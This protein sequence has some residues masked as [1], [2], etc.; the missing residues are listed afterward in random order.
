MLK[1]TITYED[2]NGEKV[3][4]DFYFNLSKAEIARLDVSYQRG[5]SEYAKKLIEAEDHATVVSIFED[6][7][8]LSVGV[9][10]EDGR[11][12]IKSQE[13]TNDFMQ[14]NAY[15]ELFMELATNTNKAIE[16]FKGLIPS[17][18]VAKFEEAQNK[19]YSDEELL[20]MSDEEFFSVA[21]S[22]TRN[23]SKRHLNLAM[24]RKNRVAS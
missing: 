3:T 6:L 19:E 22:D 18:M 13:I 24:K 9:R 5:L 12:F 14:T 8:K 2:F 11:R 16:F 17:D 4:E 15:P 1:K 20:D 23:M 10:S 7:I 21:G